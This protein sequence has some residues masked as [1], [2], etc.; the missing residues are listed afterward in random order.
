[1]LREG[2][3]EEVLATNGADHVPVTE[4]NKDDGGDAR[5]QL[6]IVDTVQVEEDP[7][8]WRSRMKGA[9][10]APEVRGGGL[11]SKKQSVSWEI[12]GVKYS[13]GWK[14]R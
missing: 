9:E 14:T 2:D 5:G 10:A 4:A 8:Q 11:L 3:E 12:S 7:K 13:V 6:V 1:M